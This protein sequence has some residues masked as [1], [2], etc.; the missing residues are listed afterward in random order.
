[1]TQPS[2][3]QFSYITV[4]AAQMGQVK[5]LYTQPQRYVDKI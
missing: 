1:M 3:L 2:A 4:Y 5:T